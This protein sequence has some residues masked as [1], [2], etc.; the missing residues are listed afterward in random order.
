MK[1]LRQYLW[2]FFQR[3]S[4]HILRIKYFNRWAV[5]VIDLITWCMA[6]MIS[7]FLY[8]K[9]AGSPEI[10]LPFWLCLSVSLPI[11]FA[12]FYFKGMHT[13]IIRYAAYHEIYRILLVNVFIC[14]ILWGLTNIFITESWQFYAPV[15]VISFFLT[16]MGMLTSR[17]IMISLYQLLI[18]Y[19]GSP[20]QKCFIWGVG[21]SSASLAEGISMDPASPFVIAGFITRNKDLSQQ[22]IGQYPVYYLEDIDATYLLKVNHINALIFTNREDLIQEQSSFLKV[23]VESKVSVYITPPMEADVVNFS[24]HKN[25]RKIRIEDLLGRDEINI[26]LENLSKKLS[27]KVVLVTGAAGSIGSELVFQIAQFNPARVILFDS[28]ETPLHNI[29]LE[30]TEKFPNLDFVFIIGDVRDLHRVRNVFSEYH[31]EC[32]YHA[33]AY[34]HVPMMEENPCEAVMVN[35]QGTRNVLNCALRNGTKHFVMVSTD[36]AVNPTNVMGASK[37]IAEIYVQ[38]MSKYVESK[39]YGDSIHCVTTRFGNVL[40]SNG[41]VIPLFQEQIDKGGPI[42]VTHPDIIR[43]FMTIPEACRLVLEAG[44][45]GKSGKIYVFDMGQPVRIKDM[46][47]RMIQ[48]SGLKP[49]KDIEIR[50]TGLRPGEKLY[51]ELLNN[52]ENATPTD[53]PKILMSNVREYD[54]R[55]VGSQLNHLIFLASHVDVQGTVLCMKTIAPEYI[56]NNSEFESLDYKES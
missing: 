54:L 9:M 11:V 47:E 29:K 56:S 26:N 50:Y 8:H 42:T 24:T 53:H 20:K 10:I 49:G 5:M 27:D 14:A 1:N 45:F 22:R 16:F 33:A 6:L 34:K 18:Q 4:D 41:S 40:G 36:K 7:C 31:P 2:A 48:L 13:G 3:Y 51:E 17:L 39:G 23:C 35:V 55:I 25:I 46:A 30:I 12:I 37:R 15:L 19:S 52:G 21:S 28:A 38:A 44:S 43:Y 32:V